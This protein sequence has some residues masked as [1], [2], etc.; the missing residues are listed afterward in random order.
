V[1]RPSLLQNWERLRP[2]YPWK[3]KIKQ[4]IKKSEISDLRGKIKKL[5]KQLFDLKG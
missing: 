1:S 5:E 2:I 3:R 4:F